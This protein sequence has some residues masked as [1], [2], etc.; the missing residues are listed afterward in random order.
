M[1]AFDLDMV[2]EPSSSLLGAI[3]RLRC[4][5]PWVPS[6]GFEDEDVDHAVEAAGLLRVLVRAVHLALVASIGQLVS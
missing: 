6:A 5:P 3:S 1:L 2:V 4:V